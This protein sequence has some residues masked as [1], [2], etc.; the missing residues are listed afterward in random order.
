MYISCRTGEGNVDGEDLL[1]IAADA[2]E[3]RF[4]FPKIKER[5]K[6][7]KLVLDNDAAEAAEV[8]RM[9]RNPAVF[10][11][12]SSRA[13]WVHVVSPF[14]ACSLRRV[15]KAR[16][17]SNGFS[18]GEEYCDLFLPSF[19]GDQWTDSSKTTVFRF[20]ILSLTFY[21]FIFRLSA[22]R[23]RFHQEPALLRSPD[24]YLQ[25]QCERDRI[26]YVGG[27]F[28]A[29]K[30]FRST[31]YT[32]ARV[33][34]LCNV[35]V[36]QILKRAFSHCDLADYLWIMQQK[37]LVGLGYLSPQIHLYWEKSTWTAHNYLWY[38]FFRKWLQSLGQCPLKESVV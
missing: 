29:S 34:L 33:P 30:L 1:G 16:R 31:V 38:F 3:L 8:T 10:S 7:K 23:W 20:Y 13:F 18:K 32:T 2:D 12:G 27:S 19:R 17:S 24:Q 9:A 26:H 15:K 6:L 11:H 5:L 22:H 4:Y 36:F 35:H 28:N 37:F 21:L 25:H 14:W